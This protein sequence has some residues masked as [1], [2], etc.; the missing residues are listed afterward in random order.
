[1]V[2]GWFPLR[3]EGTTQPNGPVCFIANAPAPRAK[4]YHKQS[5]KARFLA[6][7]HLEMALPKRGL[8]MFT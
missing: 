2:N 7:R 4:W 8:P 1:M 5:L 6:T 3:S